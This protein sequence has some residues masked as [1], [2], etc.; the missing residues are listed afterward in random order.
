MFLQNQRFVI[1]ADDADADALDELLRH[2]PPSSKPCALVLTSQFGPAIITDL[3]KRLRS[4]ALP[5][6]FSISG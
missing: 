5:F 6:K 3:L 1:L 2:V 4:R